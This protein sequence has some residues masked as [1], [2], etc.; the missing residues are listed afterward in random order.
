MKAKAIRFFMLLFLSSCLFE[1]ADALAGNVYGTSSVIFDFANN[2]TRGYSRTQL[3]YE[4]AE[5]YT[6]YVCGE[7]YKN[8]VYQVRSCQGGIITATQWTQY[9]GV[10][11]TG[12]VLSDH[13]VD[14]KLYDEEQFSYVDYEGYRFLRGTSNPIEWLYLPPDVF[15]Y[16][17]PVSINLGNTTFFRPVVKIVSNAF[18]PPTVSTSGISQSNGSA[19]ITAST[20]CAN[21]ALCL[22]AGDYA[23]VEMLKETS[24]G[25]F[26]FLPTSRQMNVVLDLGGVVQAGFSVTATSSPP[27][28]NNVFTFSYRILDVRRPSGDPGTPDDDTSIGPQVQLDPATGT[29]AMPRTLTVNP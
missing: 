13:Y 12:Y 1:A 3:D 10:S 6:A 27:A 25:T 21:T 11:S 26:N 4:T 19:S 5:W 14:M 8:G 7:L 17:N 24:G 29:A 23:V 2:R 16:R 18:S 15:G 9:T 22:V 20:A 28:P